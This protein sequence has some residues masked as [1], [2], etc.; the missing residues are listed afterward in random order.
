[1]ASWTVKPLCLVTLNHPSLAVSPSLP[2]CLGR[3][4]PSSYRQCPP[5]LHPL[6]PIR[7]GRQ[8]IFLVWLTQH[9]QHQFH[10]FTSFHSFHPPMHPRR[11]ITHCIWSFAFVYSRFAVLTF[12]FLIQSIKDRLRRP[13]NNEGT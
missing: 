9:G 6:N 12:L 7:S 11:G 10:P 4:N 1:M 2:Q 8:L 13:E 5:P 3:V